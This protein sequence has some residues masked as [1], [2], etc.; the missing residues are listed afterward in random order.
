[1]SWFNFLQE[2]Q[3]NCSVSFGRGINASIA[4]DE[5]EL[6]ELSSEAFE[7][8]DILNAYEL[9]FQSLINFSQNKSNQN[10]ILNKTQT[11]LHFEMYQGLAKIHGKVTQESLYAEIN[12]IKTVDA[13]VAIK[14]YILERNYQLTY[15]NY[16][17]D[18]EF[19][20]LKLHQDNISL[21]PQKIFFPL[22]ELA[23]NGDFD[24]EHIKSEFKE[25]RLSEFKEIRL[26]DTKYLQKVEESELKVK[27]RYLILWIDELEKKVLTLPSNDNTGMQSF[28]YLNILFKID[29]LLSIKCKI[30]HSLAKK[31]LEYFSNEYFTIE[32]KNEE[33]KKYLLELRELTYETFNK[34]FYKAKY[35]FNPIDKSSYDDIVIFINES[36][37]KIRWYKHNR[38]SQVIPTIYEYIAF[39]SLYNYGMNA[40]L[41]DLFH[42]LV[43]VQNSSFFKDLGCSAL[44]DEATQKLSKRS[45][46]KKIKNVLEQ[47]SQIYAS[48]SLDTNSLNFASL[49]EFSNSYYIMLKNLDFE[50][51]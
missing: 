25:I 14:R 5:E 22:R 11:E 26:E 6:F 19:I 4:P 49:N 40:T 16:F 17:S 30:R 34:S 13:S 10:I 12:I 23:L 8:K 21:S 2:T 47:S 51:V 31:V 15:V 28:L 24:K 37:N 36:Q 41:K 35:T 18:T 32:S 20:K 3:E 44:Y 38:Y 39:Y 1:M 9:F 42:I 29:Y 48:L 33:L 46:L 50:E 45:I 27:Y 43:E 7:K